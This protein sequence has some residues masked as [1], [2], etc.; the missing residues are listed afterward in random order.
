MGLNS[1]DAKKVIEQFNDSIG[2]N[3][4]V[5]FFAGYLRS[6][7]IIIVM[8]L[9][10]MI[11]YASVPK[12]YVGYCVIGSA[13]IGYFIVKFIERKVL[14]KQISKDVLF[15]SL[16]FISAFFLHVILSAYYPVVFREKTVKNENI[17]F[18]GKEIKF[19]D[20]QYYI[21]RTKNYFFLYNDSTREAEIVPAEYFKGMKIKS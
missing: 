13:L 5:P 2:V 21:G 15:F 3:E 1:E 18:E 20:K 19:N 4:N 16:I 14:D 11:A 10:T 12:D 8:V 9:F 7:L 17:V 6:Y